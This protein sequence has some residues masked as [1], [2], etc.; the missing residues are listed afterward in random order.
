MTISVKLKSRK[1]RK[2]LEDLAS[3][4]IIEISPEQKKNAQQTKRS[5][6]LKT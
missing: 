6:N 4:N 2:L 3:L 1:A 5:E